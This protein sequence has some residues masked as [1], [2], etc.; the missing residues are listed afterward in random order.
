MA[1]PHVAGLLALI[2]QKNPKLTVDEA[3]IVLRNSATDLGPTG[4]DA[5]SGSGLINAVKSA[6]A[7]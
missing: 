4:V 1:A 3:L 6:E 7:L 2:F 5:S